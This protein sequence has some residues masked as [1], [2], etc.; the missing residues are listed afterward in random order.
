MRNFLRYKDIV[1]YRTLAG[2]KSEARKN[3]LGYLWFIFEP[4]LSTGVLYLAMSQLTG[5]RGTAAILTILIGM[6][7]WQW[8]EG[9]IMLSAASLTTKFHIHQQ[10]P[11]PKYLFP[12]VDIGTNTVR[13]ACAFTIVLIVCMVI[14]QGPHLALIWLPL[15]LILQL[16][17]IIGFS[18]V[19]SI[20][21][22]L[23]PDLQMLLQSLF[24]LL[25]FVSGIFFTAE[26][27]PEHLLPYFHANPVAVLIEAYR[28]ILLEHQA[29]DFGLLGYT[30]V[31]TVCLL[32]AGGFIQSY[33][34]QRLLKLT[35]V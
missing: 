17:L 27:V 35:N 12:L 18:L 22:T 14:S 1:F 9:S 8:F 32:V 15:V 10:V 5:H 25:F 26:R 20:A 29:P 16:A 13:F 34:D 2:L 28:A 19:I 24:R 23:L 33:F 3:Y 6:L 31:L 30:A 11:L 4:L 21:V 7:T